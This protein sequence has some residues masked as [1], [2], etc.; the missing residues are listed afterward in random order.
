MP[1]NKASPSKAGKNFC[2]IELSMSMPGKG[3][4]NGGAEAGLNI[5]RWLV[6]ERL[7]AFQKKKPGWK[8]GTDAET[9]TVAFQ[10]VLP[11]TS[12]DVLTIF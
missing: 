9:K 12:G 3:E 8:L 7:L 11:P 5:R 4:E 2:R 1:N 10:E 6:K